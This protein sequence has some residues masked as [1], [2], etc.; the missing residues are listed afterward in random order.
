MVAKKWFGNRSHIHCEV[1]MRRVDRDWNFFRKNRHHNYFRLPVVSVSEEQNYF[2]ASIWSSV[3]TI[4]LPLQVNVSMRETLVMLASSPRHILFLF[5]LGI[6]SHFSRKFSKTIY[7][8]MKV[9]LTHRATSIKKVS[10][11]LQL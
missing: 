3:T 5:L 2:V 9:Y 8:L 1:R 11:N 7:R 6:T 10:R 4:M